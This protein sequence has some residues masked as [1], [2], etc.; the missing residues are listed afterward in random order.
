MLIVGDRTVRLR[1]ATMLCIGALCACQP[2]TSPTSAVSSPPA[3]AQTA[4][5]DEKAAPTDSSLVLPGLFAADHRRRSRSAIRQIQRQD[6]ARA[7]RAA[8]AF[9]RIFSGRSDP[10]SVCDV[11]RRRSAHGSRQHFGEGRGF[12]L[13][14]QARRPRRHVVL[15]AAQVN[16]KPFG[17]NGF[18]SE[19][20]GSVHD[21]WSPALD[22]DDS[23][24]GTLDVEEGEHMYF[25]V[26]LGLRDSG[27][28]PASAY[29]ADEWFRATIRV[30]RGWARWLSSQVSTPPRAWTTNGI[31]RGR[32][33]FSGYVRQHLV[34]KCFLRSKGDCRPDLR[35]EIR[36]CR[37]K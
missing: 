1:F 4:G 18:D 27:D 13:A 14:W 21:Q 12:I 24:L 34:L 36:S 7:R 11:S 35:F 30:F 28:I 2:S 33:R 3:S 23:P 31:E 19:R 26:D 37:K 15:R 6:R 5:G 25:G 8:P 10:Q 20:R 16:G 22:D 17:F 32:A 9:R 29:P